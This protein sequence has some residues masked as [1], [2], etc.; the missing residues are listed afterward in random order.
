[1]MPVRAMLTRKTTVITA[2]TAVAA[3][4]VVSIYIVSAS[5]TPS[6]GPCPP[7]RP[8][9]DLRVEAV[10]FS[11]R[12]DGVRLAGWLVPAAGD[13]A[14]VLIHGIDSDAWMGAQPDLARAYRDAG[15]DVLLFDLRAHGESEGERITLGN[16][17][18]GDIGS[19][20]ELL[21]TRGIPARHIALH[22]TSYGAAMAI[23]AA[24]EIPQIGAVVAD[25]AYADIRDLIATEVGRRTL[26]PGFIAHWLMRPG[27]ETAARMLYGLDVA[28]LAP[29]RA[30]ARIADRPVLLI[31][32]SQDPV[33]PPGHATRLKQHAGEAAQLWML[34]S[35]RH[36]E[37]VRLGRC[38]DTP[39]PRREEFLERVVSFVDA[40]LG[41]LQ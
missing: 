21:M 41:G 28:G 15:L 6:R 33:I 11:N 38:S 1:M 27:I 22:G 30:L 29:E 4:C 36:T 26:V 40:A 39:S 13:R 25:S 20:V 31:H 35:M 12:E 19:A 16:L 3:Y 2:V 24:A 8:P 7:G 32:G 23:V 34:D 17:E 9:T 18:R 5:L 14:V 37:G 10:E